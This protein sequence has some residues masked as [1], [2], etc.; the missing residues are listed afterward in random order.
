MHPFLAEAMVQARRREAAALARR[1]VPAAPRHRRTRCRARVA[2]GV[3]LIS[4]GLRLVDV[5]AHLPLGHDP[6]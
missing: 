4:L 1:W 3:R 6:A 2:V 5:P